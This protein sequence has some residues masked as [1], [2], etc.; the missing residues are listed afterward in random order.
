MT[1]RVNVT[2]WTPRTQ[3]LLWGLLLLAGCRSGASFDSASLPNEFRVAQSSKS[4]SANLTRVAT[5]GVDNALIGVGDVLGLTITTGYETNQVNTHVLRV[6]E[7]GTV[8]VPLVGEVAVAGFQPDEAESRIAAASQE[9][10]VYVNPAVTLIV[11]RQHTIRVTVVGAVKEPGVYELPRS[12]SDLLGALA[13]A[14]GRTEEA[15][16]EIEILRKPRVGPG[17]PRFAPPERNSGGETLTS[18]ASG[19]AAQPVSMRVNLDLVSQGQAGEYDL[20]DGD[21]VM[22]F[23]EE[24]RVI[25][26]MGLV[27][28]PGQFEIPAGENVH[29]LDAIALAGGRT[30]QIADK[31]RV[32]RR[33]PGRA[34][35]LVIDASIKQAKVDGAANLRLGSGDLVSVEETPATMMVDIVKSFMRFG[36]SASAPVF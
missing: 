18:Y 22:V 16:P 33:V 36:I 11:K 35:P 24:K 28:K 12:S 9:R 31:V 4:Q 5:N 17:G 23:P 1:Q 13:T 10:G 19:A 7:N 30:L 27:N 26:V 32:V 25:H 6:S 21:V 34:E 15:G 2:W 20:G 14:G 29:L 3:G 8:R